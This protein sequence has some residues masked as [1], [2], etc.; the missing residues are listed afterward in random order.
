MCGE[1]VGTI[2]SR[3]NDGPDQLYNYTTSKTNGGNFCERRCFRSMPI[4]QGK[5]A[6]GAI[7]D[8]D[9]QGITYEDVKLESFD[10]TILHSV[11]RRVRDFFKH[12]PRPWLVGGGVALVLVAMLAVFSTAWNSTGE[13]SSQTGA[14][15]EG[16]TAVMS[17]AETFVYDCYTEPV[18]YTTHVKELLQYPELPTGCESVSLTCVLQAMGYELSKTDIAE[19]YLPVDTVEFDFID[20]FAGD[21]SSESGAGAFPP[22]MVTTANAYLEAQDATEKAND[23]SGCTFEELKAYVDEGYPVMV[24]T[25]MYMVEP[26][27]LYEVDGYPWYIN[28][29][30]VVLYGVD[31]ESAQVMD[32]LEGL[33]ERDVSEFARI[34]E[35]CGS[36]AMVIQ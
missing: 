12:T 13:S 8:P 30:C 9:T 1:T 24:W 36:Y 32:P 23:I 27:V 14:A 34:Y 33:V 26:Y 29:H 5:H 3:E 11:W 20:H 18:A 2:P 25:T 15:R 28:E 4:K 21:P 17:R 22:A 19:N 10:K 31:G 6:V 16:V 35:A 7:K